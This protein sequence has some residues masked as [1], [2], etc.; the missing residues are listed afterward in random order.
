MR[1]T[2]ALQHSPN[3]QAMRD[4]VRERVLHSTD[5]KPGEGEY[6]D[7][8]ACLD[9]PRAAGGTGCQTR[10]GARTLF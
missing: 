1:L 6:F 3:Y 4:I 7:L 8:D 5:L 2:V 10:G 9:R